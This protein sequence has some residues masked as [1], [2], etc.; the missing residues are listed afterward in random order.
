MLILAFK[1]LITPIL[2]GLVTLAGRRWGGAVS[3][4]LI[5]LPL[6]SG[7]ISF[8][9]AYQFGAEFAS[10]A[11]IGG[12]LGQISICIF[13]LTYSRVS[14]FWNWQATSIAAITAFLISTFIWNTASWQL[15]PAFIALLI[16]IVLAPR[17]MPD[18][19]EVQRVFI[20]PRWDLPA[21]IICATGF[22]LVLTTVAD[23]LGPQLSGLI[24][25]F[26]VFGVVFAAF[27]HA[28]QGSQATSRLLRGIVL[29]SGSYAAFFLIVGAA[30]PQ[31]GIAL[32]YLLAPLLAITVSGVFYRATRA[33]KAAPVT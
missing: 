32:T 4:L 22:V 14:Q 1:L 28:Q 2:I 5:G 9:L 17:F 7:P 12:L 8:I 18:H 23:T 29:G 21:R 19:V 24:A 10:Q 11:A 13:C 20:A 26:P 30:L 31:L 15:L 6:T 27:S 25:P 16:A 33:K 3:G